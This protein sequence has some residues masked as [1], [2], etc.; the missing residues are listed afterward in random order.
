M[1]VLHFRNRQRTKRINVPLL[2]RVTLFVLRDQLVLRE[3]E[4]CVHLVDA[5]AMARVNEKF[6]QHTGSTD[7]ITF[8]YSEQPQPRAATLHGEIF[9]SIPDAVAQAKEFNTTWQAELA[10]YVIHG[11]L[12]LSGFDD[13]EPKLRRE[14]KR[15]ENR[16]LKAVEKEFRLRELAR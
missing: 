3:H 15:E 5:A 14:M 13:L 2:R 12:H 11:L 7:V 1:T 8:D 4:L 6:L 16:L 9:I 10:R